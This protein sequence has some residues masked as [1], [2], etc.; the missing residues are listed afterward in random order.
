MQKISSW[1]SSPKNH[2]TAGR[3]AINILPFLFSIT[4]ILPLVW[5]FYS[6]LKTNPQFEANII[7]LPKTLYLE[8]YHYVFTKT[9]ILLYLWNTL[10]NTVLAMMG[11]LFF[12]FVNGY[13]L[14][15][16]KFKG[17]NFLYGCYVCAL[18]IPIHALLVPTYLVFS[19]AHMNNQWYS[20]IFPMIATQLTTTI[21]LISS[22]VK[23]IPVA[24]EEAAA[25]DGS[26]FSRTMFTIILPIALPA[27]VTAGIIAFFHCWNE[28]SYSL[29]LIGDKKLFTISLSLT[30]FKGENRIDYPKMMTAMIIA[31]AP[32]IFTYIL[33][34]KHIIKGLVAGA[35]K[36]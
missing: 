19:M 20:T 2:W 27:L 36:G 23:T 21:F 16:F 8:N 35:L 22:Y 3:I 34:S 29:V 28:F 1:K 17:R 18:F 13:F 11:I 7:A 15:R 33:F 14:S 30:H 26:P 9:P 31:M 32:A 4:C 24:L 6:T 10:R 5:L 25:I 12:G